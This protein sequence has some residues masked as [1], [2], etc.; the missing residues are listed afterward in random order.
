MRGVLLIVACVTISLSSA[1]AQQTVFNVPS[2]DVLDRGKLYLELDGTY[3]RSTGA[4]TLTPRTVVGL[5][6]HLEVGINVNGLN[7]PG[8]QMLT[9]TPT[10]KW[11]ILRSKKKNWIWLAGDDVFFP[12]QNRTYSAG[13]YFWTEIAHTW[14]SGSR[15]TVGGFQASE[16]VLSDKQFL[17]AQLA[18]EQPI[19][20]RMTVA[21][22]WF[23]GDSSVG[24]ATPGVI[25]K[26]S[27]QLTWYAAY[28]LG[29]HQL[30]NGNHQFLFE[31]GWNL[32]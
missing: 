2:A 4:G 12:A 25:V 5:G 3:M 14:K 15:L 26:V 10:I 13:N 20:S 9:P 24:Y 32:N 21:A 6:H 31:L 28:Q 23:S 17:G 27:R 22:D 1:T 29:N 11:E 18:F 8:Q 19:N 7:L 30:T 16:K